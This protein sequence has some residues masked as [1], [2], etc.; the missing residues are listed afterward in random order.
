MQVFST[1]NSTLDDTRSPFISERRRSLFPSDTVDSG[2]DSDLGPIN[3]LKTCYSDSDSDSETPV[4]KI[5]DTVEHYDILE[6][7]ANKENFCTPA[8]SKLLHPETLLPLC[9][10]NS[11]ACS[12]QVVRAASPSYK[13][14]TPHDTCSTGTKLPKLLR[15]SLLDSECGQ[16]KR[17]LPPSSTPES[18]GKLLKMESKVRTALFPDTDTD[19]SLP[20]KR[21]YSNTEDIMETIKKRNLN[22]VFLPKKLSV[23]VTRSRA[24][25]RKHKRTYGEINAGVTHK[26]RKPTLGKVVKRALSKV[27]VTPAGNQA[28]TEYIKDLKELKENKGKEKM[29]V[30]NKENHDSMAEPTKDTTLQ[31]KAPRSNKPLIKPAVPLI[32]PAIK[33]DKPEL[34]KKRPHCSSPEQNTTNKKFF[35]FRS[36]PKGVVTMNK[37]I[38]VRVENGEMVLLEQ[39]GIQHKGH[40][41]QNMNSN[42]VKTENVEFDESDFSQEEPSMPS[43]NIDDILSVLDDESEAEDGQQVILPVHNSTTISLDNGIQLHEQPVSRDPI[44]PASIILSPISQMCNVT[45]GLDLNSPKRIKN[46]APVLEEIGNNIENKNTTEDEK[47]YPVFHQQKATSTD[48]TKNLKAM[49]NTVKKKFK[50]IAADQMLLDAGQKRFGVTQCLECQFMY[51]L[52]DPSDEMIHT[53]YHQAIHIFRFHGWKN[54]RMVVT[55]NS[56]RIIQILPHDSK[57]WLKRIQDL[58]GVVDRELGYYDSPFSVDNV[59]T[60]LYVKNRLI[61]GCIVAVPASQGYRM[62]TTGPDEGDFCSKTVC[63]IKCGISRIWVSS[64]HRRQGIGKAL[65]DAVKANFIVGYPLDDGEIAMSS[66]TGMGKSFAV[67]YFGTPNFLV[68]FP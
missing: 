36:R 29:I 37:N 27:A 13:L 42:E 49:N 56:D 66:P 51:H 10:S 52:G 67:K 2:E 26:I 21:F 43:T 22:Q 12:T 61:V 32:T 30:E 19:I 35:R 4:S 17:K 1:M 33:V 38:K 55:I 40:E 24:P 47:L 50:K 11:P 34:S 59:Q 6:V 62:L 14:K 63:P 58:M 48:N 3:P 20:A 60:F 23:Q 7:V 46:L 18:G 53:N 5:I 45:S 65:M 25:K 41:D 44:C 15:K 8:Q 57:L 68:Y 64:S 16:G 39:N 9:L 54:E 28:I 31:I